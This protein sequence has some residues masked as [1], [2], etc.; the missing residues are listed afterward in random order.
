MVIANFETE[1]LT[2]PEVIADPYG[3]FGWLRENDSVHWNPLFKA[4]II[5]RYADVVWV[6]HNHELFSS[7]VPM[8][9]QELYPPIH[10][11][12]REL[13][14]HFMEM[15]RPFNRHDRPEHLAMRQAIHRWF[16]PKAIEHWRA[17][18]R[19]MAGDLID[20]R[21]VD[22]QMEVKTDFATPL[23]LTTISWMLDVPLADAP[24]LRD[25]A[26]TIIEAGSSPDRFRKIEPAM[27]QLQE[28]F[29]PLIEARAKESG[30]DLVSMLADAE[31]RGIFTRDQCVSS[32]I[33]LLQAGHETM[34]RLI[35]NGVLAF[36][37]NPDQWD[38]LRSD[39]EGLCASATEEC[40]RYEPSIL[41][42]LRRSTQDVELGGTRI[43]AGDR[44][45]WVMASANRD[46]RV[47]SDP[48]VFD[49]R[50]SPNPHV[51]F[52]G[53]IHHCLGAALARVEGQEAFRALSENFPRL[54][55][56]S[57]DVERP[58]S[59]AIRDVKS[60]PIC[61]T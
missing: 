44:A 40:L 14:E 26:A 30:E 3:Y 42:L 41:F 5:T 36:I 27:R 16:T 48:D 31:R 60:L 45:L 33:L 35:C 59:P 49:I 46:P 23:P 32:V 24:R 17:E 11:D 20:A 21:R 15:D 28:Y 9:P 12:D 4:W 8:D 22:G 43:R 19:G 6:L 47:F 54:R 13:A 52:G 29:F 39:P 55:L 7:V 50:R 61:W 57:Y 51:S 34:L 38:L 10:E 25:L 37:H 18:L 58:Q 53:G 1:D 56:Q 2:A